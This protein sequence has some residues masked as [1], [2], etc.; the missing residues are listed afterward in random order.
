MP[1]GSSGQQERWI[2]STSIAL[3]LLSGLYFFLLFPNETST[4]F[5]LYL[6]YIIV[7]LITLL[8]LVLIFLLYKKQ[9][10]N[11]STTQEVKENKKIKT[12]EQLIWRN[13]YV[14]QAQKA[15]LNHQSASENRSQWNEI[16]IVFIKKYIFPV[17]SEEDVSLE[18]VSELIEKSL[19]GAAISG[20]R[21]P[22]YSVR[23]I[24]R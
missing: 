6:N 1:H 24:N 2:L 16:K 19:R 18:T 17:V 13:R 21:P 8:A 20:I 15:K 5:T 11:D 10:N 9:Q 23:N 14:L 12:I 4:V 7:A 3:S 22:T